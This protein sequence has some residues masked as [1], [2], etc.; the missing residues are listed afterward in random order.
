MQSHLFAYG[1]SCQG[2]AFL[3]KA[4]T[5]ITPGFHDGDCYTVTSRA[6][7]KSDVQR[8][9]VLVQQVLHQGGVLN[10]TCSLWVVL[11]RHKI[12]QIARSIL[13]AGQLAE[14]LIWVLND[15]QFVYSSSCAPALQKPKQRAEDA[16]AVQ[17][18][19]AAHLQHGHSTDFVLVH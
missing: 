7:R 18:P 6:A 5:P 17:S 4:E 2:S 10:D 15:V 1:R 16:P 19:M 3:T 12:R 9:V 13:T 11:Q 8:I 14:I